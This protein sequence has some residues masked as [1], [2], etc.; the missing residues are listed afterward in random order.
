VI[1]T[2]LLGAFAKATGIVSLEN[3]EKALRSKLS[4]TVASQNFET[5]QAAYGSTVVC[6]AKG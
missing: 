1:N 4:A 2:P 3:I 6:K 5:V